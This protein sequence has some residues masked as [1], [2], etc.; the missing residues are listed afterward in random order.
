MNIDEPVTIS[1]TF[2]PDF[3]HDT[4]KDTYYP[5]IEAYRGGALLYI[6]RVPGVEFP[7][8]DK[9]GL[10]QRRCCVIAR[11]FIHAVVPNALN[12]ATLKALVAD[13]G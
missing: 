5:V 8:D 1:F 10:S 7:V 4:D 9:P 3:R 13:Y 2:R 12:E 11:G 6:V